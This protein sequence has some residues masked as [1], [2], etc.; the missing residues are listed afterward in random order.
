MPNQAIGSESPRSGKRVAQATSIAALPLQWWQSAGT[1]RPHGNQPLPGHPRIAEFCRSTGGHR[2]KG[3]DRD[4]A[5]A[6]AKSP[7]VRRGHR[8]ESQVSMG[9]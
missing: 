5:G 1:G 7:V 9:I 4:I 8:A 2:P 6:D 3:Y